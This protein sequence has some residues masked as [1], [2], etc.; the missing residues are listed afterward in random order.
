M[1]VIERRF[2]VKVIDPNSFARYMEFRG[3]TVRTL[4]DKVGCSPATIGHQRT[5][6]RKSIKPEWARAIEKALDAPPGSLFAPEVSTVTREVRR[7]SA[8]A[9]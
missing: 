7:Q 4:A 1:L 3:Y 6:E 2:D 9:A 8:G 5:G